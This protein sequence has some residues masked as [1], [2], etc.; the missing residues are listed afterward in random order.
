MSE[1]TT[2]QHPETDSLEVMELDDYFDNFSEAGTPI[3]SWLRPSEA[4]LGCEEE[5]E[6]RIA[7]KDFDR[8][9]KKLMSKNKRYVK[10]SNG[11][12]SV[13]GSSLSGR[14]AQPSF[15]GYHYA[16]LLSKNAETGEKALVLQ[17]LK[18][19]GVGFEDEEA[20]G[21][22]R[23][24]DINVVRSAISPAEIAEVSKLLRNQQSEID[25]V[26]PLYSE[27]LI[28]VKNIMFVLLSENR[29][30]TTVTASSKAKNAGSL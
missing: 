8:L 17:R 21:S 12:N 11:V 16:I 2:E 4:E 18:P 7:T 15:S 13:A 22:A 25:W 20:N 6:A 9:F 27:P 29:L 28:I 19:K 26:G 30:I 1:R 24:K 14:F 5:K 3:E 10:T 23:G